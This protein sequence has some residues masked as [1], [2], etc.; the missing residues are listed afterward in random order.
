MFVHVHDRQRRI[1]QHLSGVERQGRTMEGATGAVEFLSVECDMIFEPDCDLETECHEDDQQEGGEGNRPA[2]L[3]CHTSSPRPP[4]P[5][6]P[7]HIDD[8]FRGRNVGVYRRSDPKDPFILI[9]DPT[10]QPSTGEDKDSDRDGGDREGKEGSR[11]PEENGEEGW[12]DGESGSEGQCHQPVRCNVCHKQFCSRGRLVTHGLTH[13]LPSPGPPPPCPVCGAALPSRAALK[14]HVRRHFSGRTYQCPTCQQNHLTRT[15]MMMHQQV[16]NTYKHQPNHTTVPTSSPHTQKLTPIQ[17]QTQESVHNPSGSQSKVPPPQEKREK[18]HSPVPD[19]R[20][21]CCNA[22]FPTR[23][24]LHSHRR[25]HRERHRRRRRRRH[26][27]P[28]CGSQFWRSSALKK[29]RMAEH[30][31]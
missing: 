7:L 6:T 29:H 12:D 17:H 15:Q 27:C 26:E 10:K 4:Q 5:Q 21:E 20:C 3:L 9:F 19:L 22:T 8:L 31:M 25:S 1:G 14:I 11:S 18:T 16:H 28:E 13:L 2:H 24:A 23:S 30:D